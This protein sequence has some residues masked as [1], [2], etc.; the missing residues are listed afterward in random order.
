MDRSLLARRSRRRLRPAASRRYNPHIPPGFPL[1]RRA[2][3]ETNLRTSPPSGEKR[4]GTPLCAQDTTISSADAACAGFRAGPK[5]KSSRSQDQSD[6][7]APFRA[8]STGAATRN[9]A[10]RDPVVRDFIAQS[11]SDKDAIARDA[12]AI[13]KVARVQHRETIQPQDACMSSIIARSTLSHPQR[14]KHPFEISEARISPLDQC[15]GSIPATDTSDF[16]RRFQAFFRPPGL[17]RLPATGHT[18]P[19]GRLRGPPARGRAGSILPL[20]RGPRR[21]APARR[22]ARER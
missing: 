8:P 17:G 11:F 2:P 15:S 16:P 12:A 14:P 20:E 18:G 1:R 6:H 21:P 3:H 22:R 4:R 9:A 10:T 13:P 5:R 19:A 7:R